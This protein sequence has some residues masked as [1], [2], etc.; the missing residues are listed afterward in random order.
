MPNLTAVTILYP[1]NLMAFTS[2]V[3]L[4]KTAYTTFFIVRCILMVFEGKRGYKF[5][6]LSQFLKQ[7]KDQRY[8]AFVVFPFVNARLFVPNLDHGT[9]I[10]KQF[11]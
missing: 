10:E 2:P 8:L 7:F 11:F 5:H 6:Q 3:L 9:F 1:S 4:N